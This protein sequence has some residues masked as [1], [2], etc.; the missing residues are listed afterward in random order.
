MSQ[1][2]N[3]IVMALQPVFDKLSRQMREFDLPLGLTPERLNTLASIQEYG[4]ISIKALAAREK[5]RSATMS[6]MISSLENDGLVRRR[7]DKSDKRGVLVAI[8]AK[9]RRLFLRGNQH[10]LSQLSNALAKLEPEQLQTLKEVAATLEV[11]TSAL[12]SD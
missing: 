6:K 7:S 4:P 9:G 12:D 5:V 1:S 10:R 8:T 3:D 2:Q 11:L